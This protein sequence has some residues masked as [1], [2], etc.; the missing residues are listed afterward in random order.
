MYS[1]ILKLKSDCGC[2]CGMNPKPSTKERWKYLTNSDGSIYQ[3]DDL[4]NV[5][6]KCIELLSDNLLSS[7][8]VVQNKG[9]QGFVQIEGAPDPHV[10]T[11]PIVTDADNGKVLMVIEGEW[12][13]HEV[14]ILPLVTISDDGKVL[15]V[16]NGHWVPAEDEKGSVITI[17]PALDTGVK[18]ADYTIDGVNGELYAPAGGGGG[19]TVVITPTQSTGTKIADYSIDGVEGALY[20]QSIDGKLDKSGGTMTGDLVRSSEGEGSTT[21]GAGNFNISNRAGGLSFSGKTMTFT[22]GGDI[23]GDWSGADTSLKETIAAKQDALTPG[24]NIDITNGVISATDT[25]YSDF[26]GSAHGLVPPV[27]TQT[28]KYLKDDGTWDTPPAAADENVTQTVT[29]DGV[30]DLLLSGSVAGSS[31]ATEQTRKSG[32]YSLTYS[33]HGNILSVGDSNTSSGGVSIGWAG[34]PSISIGS[35]DNQ[36]RKTYMNISTRDIV[37]GAN[38]AGTPNTWDETNTSLKSA[39]A[40]LAKVPIVGTAVSTNDAIND[41]ASLLPPNKTCIAINI[42]EFNKLL[43]QSCLNLVVVEP[44]ELEPTEYG[45]TTWQSD[46]GN[47]TDNIVFN[48]IYSPPAHPD[49]KYLRTISFLNRTGYIS[50]DGNTLY[51]SSING[52]ELTLTVITAQQVNDMW[53]SVFNG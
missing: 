26:A 4:E 40:A 18:I 9:A 5:R 21:I 17:T 14:E 49:T 51:S 1:I 36:D 48:N 38:P 53:D 25:T 11:L 45:F 10:S 47:N 43:N 28:G 13:V 41:G 24:A 19:S 33:T 34:V 29:T 27:S 46:Q 8:K 3:E 52:Y 23:V 15:K 35:T 2:G 44:R 32:Q 7:I 12:G 37:F 31:T 39:L 30:Y 22:Q 50:T 16:V 6:L 20:T 42:N